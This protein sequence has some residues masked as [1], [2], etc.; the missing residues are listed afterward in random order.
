MTMTFRFFAAASPCTKGLPLIKAVPSASPAVLRRKSRLLRPRCLASSCCAGIAWLNDDAAVNLNLPLL[1]LVSIAH[2]LIALFTC[3]RR[4]TALKAWFQRQASTN[5]QTVAPRPF[6]CRL[7]PC[8]EPGAA[9]RRRTRAVP[10]PFAR[11][12]HSTGPDGN[13]RPGD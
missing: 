6:P 5:T 12:E 3:N 4:S 13:E 9:D 8:V 7:R 2:Q 10:D 1:P 11:R